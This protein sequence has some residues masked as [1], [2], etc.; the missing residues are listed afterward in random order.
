MSYKN[1]KQYV[2]TVS[3]SYGI[4][5]HQTYHP[6]MSWQT[7]SPTQSKLDELLCL[8]TSLKRELSI[9]NSSIRGLKKDVSQIVLFMNQTDM[10][11]GIV[12]EQ[13]EYQ[14]TSKEQVSLIENLLSSLK[15]SE[16]SKTKSVGKV[17][18]TKTDHED[19]DEGLDP[20]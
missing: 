4:P 5:Q 11:D 10:E 16:R 6:H 14:P 13:S 15:D 12:T 9:V 17:I 20:Q 7:N 2:P 18:S 1:G 8:V 3:T 19:L